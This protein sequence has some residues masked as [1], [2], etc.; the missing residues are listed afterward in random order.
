[1]L[2]AT[3]SLSRIQNSVEKIKSDATQRFSDAASTGDNFRQGDLYITRIYAVPDHATIVKNPSA[4]LAPGAT[5]GSRHILDSLVGVRV[6]V[7]P[8]ATVLDGPILDVI[9]DRT[10]THPEHGDV[11]LPMG[12]YEITY[13]RAY[14]DELRRVAD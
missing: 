6:F 1:M 12:C 10:I 3:E 4:Q 11:V 7:K 8:N 5:K 2:T 9:E 13:Q 14:A